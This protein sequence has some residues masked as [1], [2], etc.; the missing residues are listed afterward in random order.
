MREVART[1][2]TRVRRTH[3]LGMVRRPVFHFAGYVP[4]IPLFHLA[5]SFHTTRTREVEKLFAGHSRPTNRFVLFRCSA[6]HSTHEQ[7]RLEAV[8]V[9]PVFTFVDEAENRLA[10]SFVWVLFRQFPAFLHG[11]FHAVPVCFEQRV[12]SAIRRERAF[13]DPFLAFRYVSAQLKQFLSSVHASSPFRSRS[14]SRQANVF[15]SREELRPA[16]SRAG[17]CKLFSLLHVPTTTV[18]NVFRGGKLFSEFLRSG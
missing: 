12:R 8:L 17:R 3:S 11:L 10:N 18:G 7:P 5:N 16:H 1:E 13:A 9:F 14:A 15:A 6:Y 4:P 2:G